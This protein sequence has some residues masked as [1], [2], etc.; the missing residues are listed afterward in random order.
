MIMPLNPGNIRVD[1]IDLDQPG[2]SMDVLRLDLVHPVI[3]GNKWFK[4]KEYIKDAAAG[5]KKVIL[6][7]GGAYS[8]HIVATSAAAS[9]NGMKSI[10]IIRGERAAQ[11]SHTLKE[12]MEYGM[13]LHFISREEYKNKAVPTG[14][15]SS[16]KE[17]EIYTIN[18]GG[19]GINGVKGAM[20][21]LS[22]AN[23]TAYTH[24]LA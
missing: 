5:G 21:I 10:G 24:I 11:L 15:I 16:F 9:L 7:F 19:Y 4:L 13:E 18:E 23:T 3:S 14:C 8:N 20:D 6:T 2:I 22:T 17:G 12:A 1:H